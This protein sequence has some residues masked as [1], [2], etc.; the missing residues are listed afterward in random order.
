MRL[1][2]HVFPLDELLALAAFGLACGALG[3]IEVLPAVPGEVVHALILEQLGEVLAVGVGELSCLVVGD[4]HADGLGGVGLRVADKAHG[5]ALDP[6]GGVEAGDDLAVEG[7]DVAA[8]VVDDVAVIVERHGLDRVRTVAN[9]EVDGLDRP[10]GE[11]S[12][13]GD[14][15]V[16]VEGGA[17]G[18]DAGHLAVLAEDFHGL[19]EEVNL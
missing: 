9:G 2:D 8:V 19:L 7:G 5:A 4:E 10:L 12:G 16:A 14:R 15:A 17:L 3:G 13:A 1:G 18:L 6:A 11:L